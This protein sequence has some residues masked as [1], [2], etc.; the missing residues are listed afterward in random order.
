MHTAGCYRAVWSATRGGARVQPG[1]E[2]RGAASSSPRRSQ[3]HHPAYRDD[4]RIGFKA[5]SFSGMRCLCF[6]LRGRVTSASYSW[7]RADMFLSQCTLFEMRSLSYCARILFTE[8]ANSQLL[9]NSG[10]M[11]H[12]VWCDVI[13]SQSFQCSKIWYIHV[14]PCTSN[15]MFLCRRNPYFQICSAGAAV[16]LALV[17]DPMP[18][19]PPPDYLIRK[20]VEV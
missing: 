16:V 5:Q 10:S 1:R 17:Q 12:V 15:L 6:A 3:L 8:S 14:Y 4:D 20:R 7:Q 2:N 19:Q 13:F 9:P 18:I 11:W